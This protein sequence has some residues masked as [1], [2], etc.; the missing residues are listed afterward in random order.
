MGM[1]VGRKFLKRLQPE[2]GQATIEFALVIPF[3]MFIIMSLVSFG[4]GMND[5]VDGTHVANEGARLAAVDMNPGDYGATS[6]QDYI[7]KQA[8]ARDV[9]NAT[10]DICLPA[11]TSKIGAPIRVIVGVA[12]NINPF[13]HRSFTIHG[14]STM[15]IEQT[16]TASHYV[17]ALHTCT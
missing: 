4:I 15:R 13:I 17:P 5:A 11:G 12:F 1:A 14:K 8:E 7:T 16:P 9:K 10:V 3:L 2:S 6:V